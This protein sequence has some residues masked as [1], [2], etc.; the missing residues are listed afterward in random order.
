MEM[1]VVKTIVKENV[2]PFPG[3]DG[4]SNPVK[5]IKAEMI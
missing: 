1:D 5:I 3:S 4:C 2:A